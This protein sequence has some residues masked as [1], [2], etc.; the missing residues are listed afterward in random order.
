MTTTISTPTIRTRPRASRAARRFGYG[1]AVAVNLLMLYLIHGWPGWDAVP[2]LTD[3]TTAVLPYV[4]A[5]IVATVLVNVVY[6]VRDG[7]PVKAA[8]ELVTSLMSLL[9]LVRFWQVWPFDFDGVWGGW[10][11]LVYVLLAVATFGTAVSA[12]VQGVTLLRAT[13][14]G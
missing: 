1:V 8:G 13:A 4:D 5:S 10:Q 2:F 9:S 12:L 6:V 14:R 7:R 11:P 3:E